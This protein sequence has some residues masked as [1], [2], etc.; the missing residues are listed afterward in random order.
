[1]AGNV[2]D[3]DGWLPP[4]GS[5]ATAAPDVDGWLPPT[6]NTSAAPAQREI[7]STTNP[8]EPSLAE[9]AI[10]IARHA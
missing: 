3:N 8:P 9:K 5:V 4:T 1:M 2:P 10:N 7:P 6:G